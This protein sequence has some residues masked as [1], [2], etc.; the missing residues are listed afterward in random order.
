M[1][2]RS[3]Q[4]RQALLDAAIEVF[5]ER[6][7]HGAS[8]PEVAERAGIGAASMYRHFS[9]KE[10]LVNAVYLRAKQRFAEILWDR[11]PEDLP[12]RRALHEVWDRMIELVKREEALVVFL[13]MHHH[14][15]Y[16]TA[17]TIAAS[18]RIG[19]A[20]LD[21]LIRRG[22]AEGVIRPEEP[23]LLLTF[24]WGA[25]LGTWKAAR[26]ARGKFDTGALRRAEALAWAALRA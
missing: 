7:F 16:L 20:A 5:A 18:E 12:V 6:G 8:V 17:E 4:T 3:T 25:F 19:L 23:R 2:R 26:G 21:A 1:P 15:T 13:E 9:G 11:F 10:E 22:Q 14:A 24:L